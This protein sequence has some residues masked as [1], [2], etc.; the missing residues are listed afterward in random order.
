MCTEECSVPTGF[1]V[2]PFLLK[3]VV[4]S[5]YQLPPTTE[6]TLSPLCRLAYLIRS[7]PTRRRNTLH[8]ASIQARS[9]T[10]L[11]LPER[12]FPLA[13]PSLAHVAAHRSAPVRYCLVCLSHNTLLAYCHMTCG[14]FCWLPNDANAC[15]KKCSSTCGLKGCRDGASSTCC[16]ASCQGGCFADGKCKACATGLLL[17]VSFIVFGICNPI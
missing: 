6:W 13:A 17:Y 1:Q 12:S 4:L 8:R 15:Q 16:D 7:S 2:P 3:Y 11:I 14:G 9:V 10:A 5:P